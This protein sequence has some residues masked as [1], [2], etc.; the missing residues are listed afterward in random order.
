MT[1]WLL[2]MELQPHQLK[3]FD[4]P[5]R[6]FGKKVPVMRS[7]QAAWFDRWPWLH[8]IE[9]RDVVLCFHCAEAKKQKKLNWCNNADE[10]FISK[11]FYNWKDA[12]VKHVQHESSNCHKEAVLKV[13]TVKSTDVAEILS[14]KLA[15]DKMERRQCFLKILSNIR[16]LGR[17]GLPLRGHGDEADSNYMQLMKLRSEEDSRVKDWLKK[18]TDKYTSPEIQNEILKLMALSVLRQV[19][20]SIHDAPF[21]SLMID[22]T[23]DVSNK[24]Q[25][26]I[27]LRW[28]D[29]KF[30]ANEE[31]IGLHQVD[32]TTS[33]V[34]FAIVRDVLTRLN[35]SIH[36][37]RGQC[38]DGASAMSGAKRGLA[39]LVQQEEPKAIY[40]HCYGHALNLACGDAIKTCNLIKNAL[41][42]SYELIKLIK[43]SPRRDAALQ[44]I[45]E[46]LP[47]DT[48]GIRVLCLQ[49]IY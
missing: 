46:Q 37:L 9:S 39:A 29:K 35:L 7:F 10:A 41:D 43:K 42:T 4:F 25:V 16:F 18:K 32:S 12:T 45:K 14:A 23:T 6:S 33:A 49:G 38:F 22:E 24:E 8:Y 1:L 13:V 44:K 20:H 19:V 26:V 47:E 40:T 30:E 5:K 36:K 34:L 27:F 11:G 48:M 3:S 28:I 17:Q 15:K 2:A 21:C 31:F